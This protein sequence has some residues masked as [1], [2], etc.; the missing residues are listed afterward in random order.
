MLLISAVVLTV[1]STFLESAIFSTILLSIGCGGIASVCIAWLTDIRNYYQTQK[2]NQCKFELIKEE[3]IQLYK[4]LLYW[5]VSECH[6]LYHDQEKRS[7]DEW[8]SIL[9]DENRYRYQTVDTIQ[10]RC[11]SLG[12]KISE[13]QSFIDRF[14]AQSAVLILSGFPNIQKIKRFFY[15]Q[16]LHCRGTLNLLEG[17]YYKDFC[18]TAYV[19]YKEFIQNFPEF[20]NEFPEKYNIEIAQTWID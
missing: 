16:H 15:I 10:R 20:K 9:S 18:L 4:E 3:Y 8:L 6:G 7:F 17:S 11:E 2:E 12:R 1:F 14:N 19:L 5:A 13:I